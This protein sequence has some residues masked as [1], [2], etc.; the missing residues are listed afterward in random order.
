MVKERVVAAFVTQLLDE[1]LILVRL[2]LNLRDRHLL[3]S[4]LAGQRLQLLLVRREQRRLH[5]VRTSALANVI[6]RC[7]CHAA[8]G[9]LLRTC[10]VARCERCLHIR[11]GELH[12]AALVLFLIV[13]AGDVIRG[14]RQYR[15]HRRLVGVEIIDRLERCFHAGDIDQIAAVDGPPVPEVPCD[16]D[17][18]E[19]LITILEIIGATVAPQE[20]VP[21]LRCIVHTLRC[22]RMKEFEP[23]I[24]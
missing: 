20:A 24:V 17:I 19:R 15:I 13:D 22:D 18:L 23:L 6:A 7:V 14:Q 2:E 8:A 16:R 11:A 21:G 10:A 9:F 1:R 3:R 12:V 5:A 4:G